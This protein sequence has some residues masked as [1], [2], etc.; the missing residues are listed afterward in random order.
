MMHYLRDKKGRSLWENLI[1][2]AIMVG[3]IYV[4]TLYYQ[5][6]ATQAKF[7]V[8]ESDM[9]NLRLGISL[10]LYLNGKIPEDIRDLEK[11]ECIEYSAGGGIIKREYVKLITKDEEGHPI[12]P[13]GNRY[14]YDPAVGMVHSTTPGYENW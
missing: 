2:G 4:V 5:K 6:I 9:R 3:L 14:H 10:Y 1:L 7:S 11:K 8:L 12:D 13:F